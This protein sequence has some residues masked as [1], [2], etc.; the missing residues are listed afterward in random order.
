M[1]GWVV[2]TVFA[3]EVVVLEVDVGPAAV[4]K[5]LADIVVVVDMALGG[6]VGVAGFLNMVVVQPSFIL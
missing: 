1:A 5:D 3:A 4:G 2:T 6:I